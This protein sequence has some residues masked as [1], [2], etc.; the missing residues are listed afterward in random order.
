MPSPCRVAGRAGRRASQRKTFPVVGVV[1]NTASRRYAEHN[2]LV[3]VKPT[4]V[5][6]IPLIFT[7]WFPRRGGL[8][9]M[10]RKVMIKKQQ[11]GGGFSFLTETVHGNDDLLHK[12]ECNISIDRVLSACLTRYSC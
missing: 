4:F 2:V 6:V 1:G 11:P 3:D 12:W 5:E 10:A 7:V 9:N 8:L